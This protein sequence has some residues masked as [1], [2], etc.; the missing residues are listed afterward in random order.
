MYYL[1]RGNIP[2]THARI[3]LIAQ[4]EHIL[5]QDNLR[6][7]Q[8]IIRDFVKMKLKSKRWLVGKKK[9]IWKMHEKQSVSSLIFK[10]LVQ[11]NKKKLM[12]GKK[13]G[14]KIEIRNK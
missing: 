1:I 8:I 12:S 9:K 5:L 11:I 13:M 3:F 4:P 14:K 7:N 10:E 2:H 6:E